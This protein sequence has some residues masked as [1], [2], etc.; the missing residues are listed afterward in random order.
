MRK[1]LLALSGIC[2][3]LSLAFAQKENHLY[4]NLPADSLTTDVGMIPESLDANVDSLL[5][6]WH[7]QYFTK[8]EDFCE[9]AESNVFFPDSVYL[10]RLQRLPR[11][12]PMVYNPIVRNCIELYAGRKRGL[13]R[14]ML[15]MADFYFP[16]IEQKLD[17]YGLP[18]E[19]KYLAVVESALNPVALSRVGACGLWQ[20]MLP[21]GKSYG[22]EINSLLDE[23]R[24]PVKA[25]DAACRYFK[26]MYAIYGDW[27]LV[28]ASYNCGPGNVNKAIRRSGGKR[29]FWEIF[30]YLPKETRSYVPLFIAANYIMNYFCDHNLCPVQT[31]LPL[32]TDTVMVN[33]MIHLQQVSDVLH[34]DLQ[35]L[36]ALNPQYKRDIVPGNS[37]PAVLKL[38]ASDSYAFVDMED[39]ISKYRAEEFLANLIP[40]A[41][42][43]ETETSDT[44]ER[45]TH[46][47]KR[48]ENLYTISNRYGVSAKDVRKWNKLKSSKLAK[49][50]RLILFID[51][52]GVRLADK[53]ADTGSKTKMN[54]DKSDPVVK[55][56]KKKDAGNNFVSYKVKSGD[57]LY[58]IS[59]KYPGVTARVIQQTNGLANSDIRPGQV[60]KIPVV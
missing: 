56:S 46:V 18:L 36:R 9:D 1:Y 7:V 17:A 45:V 37:A 15:G 11:M 34:V 35:Q 5:N 6:S 13:V 50:K 31:T 20:F 48:G 19:L 43:G 4:E 25:T 16:L 12:I 3:T 22:L 14:Y 33:K 44:R 39:S 59:K 28:I 38:S 24:D 52:G 2:L 32:A 60:L 27:N 8:S 23:R 30:P 41:V 47:V 54:P 53:P 51:N 21:T 57:S 40:D 42:N 55:D 29:D 26:D 49:G 58:T 10:D